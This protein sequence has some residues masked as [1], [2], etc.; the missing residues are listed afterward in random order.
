M[1]GGATEWS[2]EGVVV[3]IPREEEAPYLWLATSDGNTDGVGL[4]WVQGK[5]GGYTVR[6]TTVS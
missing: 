2:Q 5:E 3:T 4:C 1:K 6:F